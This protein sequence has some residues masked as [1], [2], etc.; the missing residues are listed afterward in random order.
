VHIRR[1]AATLLIFLLLAPPPA[2]SW[3]YEAHIWINH[4]AAQRMPKEMPKFF[5]LASAQL[6]YLGPE[7]DRWRN[8][9]A[10]PALKYAQEPDHFIDMERIPADFGEWPKD[11]Y[12]FMRRLYELRAQ[13]LA[14]GADPKEADLLLPEKVGLQPYA[15]M[16]VMDRLRVAF[17]EYRRYTR[18]GKKAEATSAA[19][20]AVF[21]AGWLGHY[22]ADISNPLHTTVHYDGWTGPNPNG[23][24]TEKGIHWEF[25]GKFTRE[26]MSEADFAA[27]VKAPVRLTNPRADYMKYINDS[28][29]LVPTLYE[30]EKAGAFKDKGTPE[31]KEFIR[32]RLAVGAQMLANMWYTAWLES[33][34]DPPDPYAPKPPAHQ[35]KKN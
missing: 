33:A 25:E 9:D 29:A 22:V 14:A 5:R 26:N 10:E 23:Y 11:R 18:E 31:G 15:T 34:V 24:R 12:G 7:P 19:R 20:N 6:A 16:E 28:L 17:R 3:G 30:L 21:Y 1:A 2:V 4:V 8:K 32:Q 13:R 35:P 27:L